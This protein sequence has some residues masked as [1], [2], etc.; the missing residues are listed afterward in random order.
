M[1]S[2]MAFSGEKK[3]V[4]S[5]C[6][7]DEGVGSPYF[8]PR[9]GDYAAGARNGESFILTTPFAGTTIL[10]AGLAVNP[11]FGGINPP[12][13]GVDMILNFFEF[14]HISGTPAAGPIGL[15]MLPGLTLGAAATDALENV[16]VS[17][18]RGATGKPLTKNFTAVATLIGNITTPVPK[19]MGDLGNII[20]TPANT[21]QSNLREL[22]GAYI[23]PPGAGY[24]IN[25]SGTGTT[26]VVSSKL[27]FQE[28]PI[29]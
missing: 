24:L 20:G 29:Q 9:Y 10:A 17:N 7:G 13:S 8:G 3:G 23:I 25:P 21:F 6:F 28:S 14:T 27:I 11:L 16:G 19:Y 12:G 1:K 4:E 2:L 22:K 26:W 5:F 18:L 15:W